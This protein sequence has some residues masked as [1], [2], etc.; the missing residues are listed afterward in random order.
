MAIFL[1]LCIIGVDR[2]K[3]VKKEI[4]RYRLTITFNM[5]GYKPN[6][7][8]MGTPLFIICFY[9]VQILYPGDIKDDVARVK[10]YSHTLCVGINISRTPSSAYSG[11]MEKYL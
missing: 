11:T 4:L 1:L 10:V 9:R 3:A 5:C 8:S 6:R 7:V 2:I